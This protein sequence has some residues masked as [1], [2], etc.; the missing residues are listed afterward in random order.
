M[1]RKYIHTVNQLFA[2]LDDLNPN[3]LG[4]NRANH[5]S[6]AFAEY[7]IAKASVQRKIPDNLSFEEAATLGVAIM[8]VVRQSQSTCRTNLIS[9]ML[10]S[11]PGTR[12][13]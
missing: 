2:K 6:G 7:A 10:T 13:V 8:T 9:D 5:E 11:E 1:A 12:H 4:R 3:P